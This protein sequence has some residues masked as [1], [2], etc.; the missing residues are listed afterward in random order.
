MMV[1]EQ[2][3]AQGIG[4]ETGQRIDEGGDA[5][6]ASGTLSGGLVHVEVPADFDHQ[7]GHPGVGAVEGPRHDRPGKGLVPHRLQT[8]RPEE[9]FGTRG[10]LLRGVEI[11]GADA[12]LRAPE[13]PAQLVGKR[14]PREGVEV[15]SR[16]R[17][18]LVGVE[19]PHI[20]WHQAG[21]PDRFENGVALCSLHHK[22]FDRGVFTISP[23]MQVLVSES[24]NGSAMFEH[25]VLDFHGREL[26][27]PLRAEYAP[28][29]TF[30]E[31]HVAEVFR[32]PARKVIEV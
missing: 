9:R 15:Y 6:Q 14:V 2:P 24:A 13:G 7:G 10:K 8:R 3:A 12:N 16:V 26:N 5:P 1:P 4:Q 31:W 18:V 28:R 19:A 23:L 20:K 27:R 22:L 11:I 32:P 17:Q 21:G 29:E 30:L 25:V